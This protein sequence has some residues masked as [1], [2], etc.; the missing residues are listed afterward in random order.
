MMM[1]LI[2]MIDKFIE[3]NEKR[4]GHDVMMVIL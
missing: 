2:P 1:E 3:D 4:N